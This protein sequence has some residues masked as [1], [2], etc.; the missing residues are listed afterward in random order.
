MEG[1]NYKWRLHTRVCV[2]RSIVCVCDKCE[3]GES[4]LE[5]LSIPLRGLEGGDLQSNFRIKAPTCVCII[6]PH[7]CRTLALERIQQ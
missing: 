1:D 6:G 5:Y 3:C 7:S 4:V 2:M